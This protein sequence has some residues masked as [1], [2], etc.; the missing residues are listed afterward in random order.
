[1]KDRLQ[2][3]LS[4]CDIFSAL[5]PSHQERLALLFRPRS[6][7]KNE[8]I[9]LKG[10][11]LGD[12][13]ILDGRPRSATAIAVENTDTFYLDRGQ[14]LDFLEASPQ[15]CIG[16]IAML[17]RRLRRV[18]T[19]MEEISFLGVSGR[20][21]RNLIE[22]TKRSSPGTLRRFGGPEFF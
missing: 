17:C 7:H 10:D 5:E 22:M 4:S 6:F 20:I 9:F 21:A 3:E 18:S 16:I 8:I 2:L 11:L 15:A 14:F 19:Q 1:M 13:A 12:M